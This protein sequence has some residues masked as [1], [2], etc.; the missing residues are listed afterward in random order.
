MKPDKYRIQV[1]IDGEWQNTAE[2]SNSVEVIERY[3]KTHLKTDPDGLYRI[4]D[5]REAIALYNFYYNH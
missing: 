5:N 2:T 4:V 3:Y 1:Y